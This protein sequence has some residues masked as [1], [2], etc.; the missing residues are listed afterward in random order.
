MRRY[1]FLAGLSSAIALSTSCSSDPGTE[2]VGTGAFGAVGNGGTSAA[3]GAGGQA[4]GSSGSSGA[5]GA[6]AGGA[7]GGAA[8]A[9]GAGGG[10]AG[11]GG[12]IATGGTGGSIPDAGPP[13]VQFPYDAGSTEAATEACAT[14]SAE[15]QPVLLDMYII[16]DSSG[17]MDDPQTN[18]D[19]N[20]GDTTNS[21]WCKA[22]NALH[23][24]FAAPTSVG[25]GVALH[26]FASTGC[27]A[28]ATPA[29]PLQDLPGHLTQ[30]DNAMN[31]T[32]PNG[33]TNMEGALEG[34]RDYTAANQRPG[35][36]IIGILVTDGDPSGCETSIGTLDNIG[37][38]HYLNTGIP[39]FIVGMTGA[40]FS[41]LE[42]LADGAGAA[43]HTNFCGGSYSPC[44][45]YN[46]GNG[47]AAAFISALQSIQASAIGCD[48][49]MPTSSGGVINPANISVEYLSGGN[50]PPQQ[51]PRV[52]DASACGA[53][54]WYYDNNASPQRILL[55]PATCGVVQ[56]DNAA[57]INVQL[58]CLG[59]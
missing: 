4:G 9:G 38:N 55:C 59:S 13:D 45:F 28:L 30:L 18:G 47:D 51:I 26:F 56:A 29:V 48:Y 31:A 35:R 40:T 11:S 8:G 12:G 14:A 50:P 53:G 39:T 44:H 22:I 42:N 34:L 19:C 32:G 37:D 16:L 5:S 52:N 41:S 27:S 17:S 23:G 43:P 21:K 10:S 3:A 7:G 24:F 15:A 57:K 20:V 54:G 25:M 33:G 6:G 2:A 58:G 1:V 36:R 49:Q 46:V